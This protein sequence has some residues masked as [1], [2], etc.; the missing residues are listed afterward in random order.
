MVIPGH[1]ELSDYEGLQRYIVMLTESRDKIAK[2]IKQGKSLI[3]V[4]NAK[5][6]RKYDGEYGDP[7]M[8]VDRAYTSLVRELG[9]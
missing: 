4:L 2:M 7:A 8:F 5:P 9:K 6:T 3:E 1:G